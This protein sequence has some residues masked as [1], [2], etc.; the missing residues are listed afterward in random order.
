MMR[1]LKALLIFLAL[2]L[3]A[4]GF[5]NDAARRIGVTNQ[6]HQFYDGKKDHGNV[7]N[8]S[9]AQIQ[10]GSGNC[11]GSLPSRVEVN[12]MAYIS[13]FQVV[14]RQQPHKNAPFVASKYLAEGRQVQII[15]GPVC[16]KPYRY[17]RVDSGDIVLS[18]GQRG[19]II[20]WIPEE[21]GDEYLLAPIR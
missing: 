11:E 8:V 17:W 3:A 6:E 1:N 16:N 12:S 14:V 13:A 19:R 21:S 4:C 20:G 10:A 15:D 7:S 5:G 18:N 9:Q 2:L